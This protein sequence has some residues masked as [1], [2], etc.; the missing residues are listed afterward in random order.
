MRGLPRQRLYGCCFAGIIALAT[1]GCGA[2]TGLY[3]PDS[4]DNGPVDGGTPLDMRDAALDAPPCIEVPFDG[5][6]VDLQLDVS[7]EVG[8]ADIAF[9]I[10]RTASMGEE[11]DR[12]RDQLRTRLAPAIREAI[13]DS[14]LAVAT[15]ADFPIQ[16]YG[17]ESDGDSPFELR[18]RATSDVAEVQ[19][20]VRTIELSNGRD[21]EESQVEALYQLMTGAGIGRFVPPSGGCPGGGFGYACF[22]DNALPVVLL[23][24]DAEFHNG[25]FGHPYNDPPISPRPATY[26]QA[27][28]VLTARGARVIGFNSSEE[29]ALV[30]RTLARLAEDTDTVADGSPLVFDIGRSGAAL[31][32]SVVDAIRTFAG[33]VRQ[34]IDAV[35]SDGDRTDGVDPLVFIEAIVPVE[36]I[37]ADGISGID[38]VTA[39]FLDA[40]AGTQLFWQVRLRN[41]AFVPGDRPQRF[42]VRVTFRG[43]RRRLL[44]ETLI[45]IVV[46][47]TDGT[48]CEAF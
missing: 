4:G 1:A 13:P 25:P 23:F 31:G 12:I 14:Q 29:P 19:A 33:T 42:R 11:I 16:P 28:E 34:D 35:L 22:R 30:R 18:Q 9:L 21:V 37:P 2:K 10:D 27:I 47:A 36:A 32:D 5:G 26:A 15:F 7:A 48:G 8:R 44:G 24:T 46:P 20:A 17:L 43:D 6:P 38:V 3:V 45:D 39:T 40:R 41:D